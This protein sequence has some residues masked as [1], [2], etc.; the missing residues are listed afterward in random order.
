MLIGIVVTNA[1]VLV[2]LVNQYREKG[3][4]AHDATIAGGSRRLRPILMTALATIFALTPMALGIT[5]HG[6]FISQPLAIVVIGGLVS[7]T[8]LTL[9]VLPTLYNLV[10]GAKER[11]PPG[12][13]RSARRGSGGR[14]APADAR[15]AGPAAAA[16]GA[17]ALPGRI[18][19]VR[20]LRSP[21]PSTQRRRRRERSLIRNPRIAGLWIAGLGS[22]ACG[23]RASRIAGLRIAGPRMSGLRIRDPRIRSPRIRSPPGRHPSGPSL[24]RRL[25]NRRRPRA[26]SRRS[27][28]H[29][30]M[31]RTRR[32]TTRPAVSCARAVSRTVHRVNDG[33]LTGID[34][35]HRWRLRRHAAPWGDGA[36]R[37]ATRRN[38]CGGGSMPG[39]DTAGPAAAAAGSAR[40]RGDAARTPVSRSG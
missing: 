39:T 5:G 34:R 3:M 26:S 24:S 38:R 21:A 10:E 11:R 37:Q 2:D 18:R 28:P 35:R 32:R 4:N 9:L 22:R 23:S 7:S 27:P 15:G 31:A 30:W 12:V 36:G 8:V 29:M 16:A 17:A 14:L 20:R 13:R 33:S 25:P 6:G 40:R 19:W 1:I